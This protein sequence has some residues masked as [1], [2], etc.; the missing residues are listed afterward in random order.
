MGD[1]I[2]KVE[3][4]TAL[5]PDV[6]FISETFILESVKIDYESLFVEHEVTIVYAEETGGRPARGFL[7]GRKKTKCTKVQVVHVNSYSVSLQITD[8]EKVLTVIF[9]YVPPQKEY[10]DVI[11]E[12][13]DE[14]D[15]GENV[16][17]IGDMNGR[18]GTYSEDTV[19]CDSWKLKENRAMKDESTNRRGGILIKK[20][21]EH[22][23]LVVNGRTESDMEGELTCIGHNGASMVDLVIANR[24]AQKLI[25]DME[26]ISTHLSDHMILR[27]D[28]GKTKQSHEK[29]RVS[30]NKIHWNAEG[31]EE[32]S[33]IL[34]EELTEEV[35]DLDRL[36]EAIWSAAEKCGMTC[37]GYHSQEQHGPKWFTGEC[38]AMKKDVRRLLHK[39]RHHKKQCSEEDLVELI[40]D[41]RKL[42]SAYRKLRKQCKKKYYD[43]VREQINEGKNSADYWSAINIFRGTKMKTTKNS[44]TEEQWLKHYRKVFRAPEHKENGNMVADHATTCE[45]EELDKSFSIDELE[46]GIKR[47]GRKKSPGEDGIPN[48]VWKA[49]GP[50]AK[51]A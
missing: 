31:K 49:Q 42:R 17:L 47:L 25:Q 2:D 27:L 4:I 20:I 5:M 12:I 7:F 13:F 23:L 24:T 11:H 50:K 1:A 41:Y 28:T 35:M 3:E 16:L 19:R 43:D 14:V 9:M 21:D 30:C 8:E 26:V 38:K 39:I 33:E 10:D 45:I 29:V 40:D 51:D 37:K 15:Y 18:I 46:D 34:E 22:G 6:F 48:E 36:V 32:F 44:I